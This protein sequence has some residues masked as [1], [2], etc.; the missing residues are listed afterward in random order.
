M[1]TITLDQLIPLLP[2]L[3]LALAAMIVMLLPRRAGKA[4]WGIAAATLAAA[5]VMC[6]VL[7]GVDAELLGGAYRWTASACLRRSCC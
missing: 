7:W 4:A 6:A 2:E 5:A 1:N 3:L